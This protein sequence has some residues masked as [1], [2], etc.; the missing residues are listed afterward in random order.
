MLG[1]KGRISKEDD[2]NDNVH[3]WNLQCE[4]NGVQERLQ[5]VEWNQSEGEPPIYYFLSATEMWQV[6]PVS[7]QFETTAAH[8]QNIGSSLHS[9]MPGKRRERETSSSFLCSSSDFLFL[10]QLTTRSKFQGK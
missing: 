8:S 10:C 3:R 7:T 1:L 4:V 6:S 5:V 9:P 2:V